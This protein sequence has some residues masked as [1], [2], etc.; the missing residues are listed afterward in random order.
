MISGLI[1]RS[2]KFS[3][4]NLRREILTPTGTR[5]A[6]GLPVF[7]SRWIRWGS[8]K[9]LSTNKLPLVLDGG[10]TENVFPP[11]TTLLRIIHKFKDK[12]FCFPHLALKEPC[13]SISTKALSFLL[14][15]V[16]RYQVSWAHPLA[17]STAFFDP[18]T[19]IF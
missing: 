4:S 19:I 6:P 3:L 16:L 8:T 7:S 15:R 5:E 14:L 13:P 12:P 10:T 9:D 1:W 11:L 18:K 17:T 2:P